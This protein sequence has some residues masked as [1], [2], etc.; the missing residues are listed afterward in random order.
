MNYL[1]QIE[2]EFSKIRGRWTPL[3]PLDWA[4]A[5]SW[6]TKQIPLPFVFRAMDDVHKKFVAANPNRPDTINSLRYFEKGV[7]KEFAEWQTSQVGK[8]D[9]LQ[10]DDLSEVS[11]FAVLTA[12]DYDDV[13]A[14]YSLE[15]KL[16]KDNQPEPLR[17]ARINAAIKILALI[18]DVVPKKLSTS[19][20][21]T[22]LEAISAELDLSLV[23]SLP[24]EVR[25]RMLET[26][27][28]DYARI[29]INDESRQKLLIK[30]AYEFFGL[31]KL[32]LFEL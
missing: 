25:A 30:Q 18:D 29:T 9:Y 20:I 10:D 14:L 19:D 13:Q 23:L 17:S 31:P 8:A 21:E 4:L 11:G 24:D 16:Q 7:E 32:T 5:Q 12:A 27:K 26:I 6:E 15:A 2:Q 3:A 28:R 22:R 1:E